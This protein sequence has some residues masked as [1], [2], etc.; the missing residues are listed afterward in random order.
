[1]HKF[2]DRRQVIGLDIAFNPRRIGS[3]DSTR[4]GRCFFLGLFLAGGVRRHGRKGLGIQ[5]GED[6]W[7]NERIRWRVREW[8]GEG[9]G[10]MIVAILAYKQQE[11]LWNF[12]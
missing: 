8:V 5:S 1:L 6:R 7:S 2:V 12:K 11:P 3:F 4:F 9:V 10:V